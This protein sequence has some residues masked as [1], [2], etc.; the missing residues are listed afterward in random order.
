MNKTAAIPKG[1]SVGQMFRE[2]GAWLWKQTCKLAD[3]ID[4][5]TFWGM[6]LLCLL[7]RL[8]GIYPVGAGAAVLVSSVWIIR[9][10]PRVRS[11]L[12]KVLNALVRVLE[13]QEQKQ[14]Q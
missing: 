12:L 1:K 2:L 11:V 14:S 7:L 10:L 6:A 8:F 13:A 3:R 9:N 4:R 5:M